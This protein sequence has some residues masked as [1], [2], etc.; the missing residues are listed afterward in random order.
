LAVFVWT[1]ARDH[2]VLL[3]KGLA[4]HTRGR[5]VVD[6]HYPFTIRLND[7]IGGEVRPLVKID[8]GS[9]TTG[10]AAIT[11]EDGNT[12]GR[13]DYNRPDSVSERST[14]AT[15]VGEVA[16]RVGWQQPTLAIKAIRRGSYCWTRLDKYG[17]PRGD[18]MRTQ[19]VRGFKVVGG[20]A[21][22]CP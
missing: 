5:A 16:T 3:R 4:C 1:N 18:C 21:E 20:C 8:R 2:A 13:T 6:R 17:L 7:R 14:L 15:R 10:I 22:E 12:R 9:R 11:D 19:C